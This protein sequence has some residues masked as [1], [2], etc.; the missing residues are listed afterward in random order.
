MRQ[1]LNSKKGRI[2][3][4]RTANSGQE[5]QGNACHQNIRGRKKGVRAKD[6]VTETKEVCN[7]KK[8]FLF[9]TV[10]WGIQGKNSNVSEHFRIAIRKKS[11]HM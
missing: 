3:L 4:L 6:K 11:F 1:L 10:N 2:K 8:K 5:T 9:C 7:R